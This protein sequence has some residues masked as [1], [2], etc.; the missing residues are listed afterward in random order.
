MSAMAAIPCL[1]VATE[2]SLFG[3]KPR[4]RAGGDRPRIILGLDCTSSMGE[5]IKE[6][7][8]T[9]SI[10]HYQYIHHIYQGMVSGREETVGTDIV[11][12]PAI[13]GLCSPS[14]FS[15]WPPRYYGGGYRRPRR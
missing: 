8:I 5:Y 9:V 15:R 12:T 3:V 4:P 10:R 14:V 6:R 2:A 1:A 11:K 13:T 7:K